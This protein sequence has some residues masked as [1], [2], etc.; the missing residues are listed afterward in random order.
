[1]IAVALVAMLACAIIGVSCMLEGIDRASR[2]L[3]AFGIALL[4]AAAAAG[5]IA[6]LMLVS[7]ECYDGSLTGAA[8][9]RA[10]S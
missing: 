4:F 9:V 6:V 10:C 2:S 3:T 1:M 5:I 7:P 8:Y